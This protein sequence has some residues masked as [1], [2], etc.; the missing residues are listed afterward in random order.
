VHVAAA[1]APAWS[2]HAVAV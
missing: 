1:T 2:V